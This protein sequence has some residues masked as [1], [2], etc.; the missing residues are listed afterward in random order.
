MSQ[1]SR[2]WYGGELA[3]KPKLVVAKRPTAKTSQAR[4]HGAFRVL[5]VCVLAETAAKMAQRR[6]L[7][8]LSLKAY[9]EGRDILGC[10][11]D[12]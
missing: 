9:R 5:V 2:R 11:R 8:R 4:G 1:A 7:C 12:G 3:Q 10:G 6:A